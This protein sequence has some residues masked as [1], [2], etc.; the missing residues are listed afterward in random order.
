[1]RYIKGEFTVETNGGF[2]VLEALGYR[3][4]WQIVSDRKREESMRLFREAAAVRW[5]CPECGKEMSALAQ[6]KHHAWHQK[7]G[8]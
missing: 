2:Q 8:R 7:G 3:S 1:M 6:N 5:S 4:E